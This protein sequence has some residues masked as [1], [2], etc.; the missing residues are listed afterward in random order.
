MHHLL[1]EPLLLKTYWKDDALWP[2]GQNGTEA[3][4]QTKYPKLMSE[5]LAFGFLGQIIN[6]YY[7]PV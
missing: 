5:G 4:N 2:R 7:D 3:I 1:T 6:I